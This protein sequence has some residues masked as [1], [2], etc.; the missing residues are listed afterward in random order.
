MTSTVGA[1]RGRKPGPRT[2]TNRMGSWVSDVARTGRLP[3]FLAACGCMVMLY[4]FLVSGDF[5]VN[6][7]TVQGVQLGDPR[8]IAGTTGAFGVSVFRVEPGDI[9]TRLATLPYVERVD[10]D[11]RLP[12]QVVVVLREREP[13]VV[14]ITSDGAY[15]VDRHGRVMMSGVH[16]G[17]PAVE[18]DSFE[19]V[20]GDDVPA[21]RIAS[22][23]AA[24]EALGTDVDALTWNQRNGLTA[25]LQDK[26]IVIFGEPDRFPLK[27]AVFQEIRTRDFVW[28]VLDLR[29]P[30]R[31]YYE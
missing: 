10:V 31:P 13:A 20:P 18:S 26:R 14:W 6:D 23:L 29:E 16:D 3:A 15:L 25:R 9:A 21:E 7:V 4:A 1:E 8:E 30:N 11:T 27:V 22:V 17:L 5:A 19:L 12:S 2:R 24:H 28:S